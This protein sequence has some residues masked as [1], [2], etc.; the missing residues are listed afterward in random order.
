[1]EIIKIL[2][3]GIYFFKKESLKLVKGKRGEKMKFGFTETQKI[4]L[5]ELGVP[6][7]ER[8]QLFESEG[9]QNKNYKLIE[10]RAV[11]LNKSKLWD[12][13]TDK[14]QPMLCSLQN[15]LSNKLCEAG[16]TQI[17]TPTI[18]SRK[19]LER[20]SIDGTH[21]LNDQVF[22]LDKKSCLRPMLAPNLYDVSKNLMNICKGP[23]RIFEIGSCFRKE[24]EGKSHLKEFTMLNIVEWGTPLEERKQRLTEIAQLVL[25]IAGIRIYDIEED[26]SVVYGQGIDIVSQD[27]FELASTSMGPHKLDNNWMIDSSWVGIGFGLERLLMYREGTEGI[28]KYSKSIAYLD[29]ARLNIK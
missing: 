15:E 20:M 2:S 28:H 6:K 10:K 1:M 13:L 18:I 19:F 23:L 8:E 4:R 12:L 3:Y 25:D 5:M 22:W 29:G 21:P 9:E 26:N 17:T 14:H 27:G 16:F 7:S 24:S 11:Q